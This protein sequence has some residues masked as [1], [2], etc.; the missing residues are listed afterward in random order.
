METVGG[1]VGGLAL[2]D[3]LFPIVFI[4]NIARYMN[5]YDW[6]SSILQ[7]NKLYPTKPAKPMGRVTAFFALG[8][9]IAPAISGYIAEV[10]GRYSISLYAGTSIMIIGIVLLVG[11]K[12]PL[13]QVDLLKKE[14]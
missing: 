14:N 8:Q 12:I 10:T 2:Y 3:G 6:N 4:S 13:R 1:K 5:Y 11:K 7:C 9:I